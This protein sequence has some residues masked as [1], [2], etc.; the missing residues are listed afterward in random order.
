M[1][2]RLEIF[3]LG[4]AEAGQRHFRR[5]AVLPDLFGV[6]GGAAVGAINLQAQRRLAGALQRPGVGGIQNGRLLRRAK[7]DGRRDHKA[8]PRTA[9]RDEN[10]KENCETVFHD[11]TS[12]VSSGD[13][14]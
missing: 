10:G 4:F 6:A 9:E 14:M 13:L 2:E 12:E 8:E 7:L 11:F 3:R 5:H 1:H